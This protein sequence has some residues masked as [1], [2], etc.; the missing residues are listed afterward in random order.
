[1]LPCVWLF[2]LITASEMNWLN[3]HLFLGRSSACYKTPKPTYPPTPGSPRFCSAPA[4]PSPPV[5]HAP[6]ESATAPSLRFVGG[7]EK[8]L[9]VVGLLSS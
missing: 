9:W 3:Y 4:K 8:S 6:T 7:S 2:T 1:M 5:S